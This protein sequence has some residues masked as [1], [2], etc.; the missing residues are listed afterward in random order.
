MVEAVRPFLTDWFASPA[1]AHRAGRRVAAAVDE[2]RE[3]VA[4][5]VGAGAG[6]V[7]FTSGASSESVR[8]SLGRTTG[9]ADVHL[10]AERTARA[11]GRVRELAGAVVVS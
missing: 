6:G 1:S 5:L 11:V 7:V 3:R 4:V 10:A 2:A 9:D 8:F